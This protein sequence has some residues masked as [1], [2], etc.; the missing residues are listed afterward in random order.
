MYLQFHSVICVSLSEQVRCI[1]CHV[2]QKIR[3]PT[4]N[5]GHCWKLTISHRALQPSLDLCSKARDTKRVPLYLYTSSW[6]SVWSMPRRGQEWWRRVGSGHT[7]LTSP[8]L[9]RPFSETCQVNSRCS[10]CRKSVGLTASGD[11][12]NRRDL[13]NPRDH[14]ILVSQSAADLKFNL[15]RGHWKPSREGFHEDSFSSLEIRN[16]KMKETLVSLFCKVAAFFREE[17]SV[18]F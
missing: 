15:F 8:C 10:R 18:K 5:R 1:P 14:W 13:T 17:I 3:T 7:S 4:D 16:G 11:A 2:V 9:G 12:M 6:V